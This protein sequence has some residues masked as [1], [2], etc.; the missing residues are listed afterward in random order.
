M[1]SV[2]ALA[3]IS[4]AS[5]RLAASRASF[6]ASLVAPRR[7]LRCFN[8]AARSKLQQKGAA[9]APKGQGTKVETANET[10]GSLRKKRTALAGLQR[11]ALRMDSAGAWGEGRALF[12][13][14]S[15]RLRAL[16]GF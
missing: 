4:E 6:K 7:A 13:V 16:F 9:K 15:A 12:L 8:V 5:Q 1:L 10:I 11:A 2:T 3:W 14:Y